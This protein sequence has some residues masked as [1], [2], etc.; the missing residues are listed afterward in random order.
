M[1]GRKKVAAVFLS[2]ILLAGAGFSVLVGAQ[3]TQD[4]PLVTLGY[5]R[6]VFT[7]T[8]L[9]QTQSKI[10]EAE[11]KYAKSLDDKI[12]TYKTELQQSGTGGTGA[13]FSVVDIPNGK[14]MW[15]GVGCE[16]MLR[17]GSARCVSSAS[18][19]L[20]NSTTGDVLENGGNLQKNHL[21]LITIENRG[22]QASGGAVKVLVRGSYTIS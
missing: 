19:G 17:V 11:G 15:G 20:I 9:Q 1:K 14:T 5:L 2:A 12:A 8:V 3:G 21:Y 6:D 22:V 16:V 18:P 13:S 7:A 10:T 4:N